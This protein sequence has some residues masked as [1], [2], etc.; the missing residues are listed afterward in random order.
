MYNKIRE[1]YHDFTPKFWV[2]IAAVFIDVI[3]STLV[4]P[5][6]ALYITKKF[7]VGM[8]QAGILLGL[9]S[10]FGLI[11]SMVGGALT[12]KFGRK[13]TTL[14]GDIF[15][16]SI[17]CL[18]WAVAQDFKTAHLVAEPLQLAV[19]LDLQLD[20][21]LQPH[22]QFG[23]LD[24][25]EQ[26]SVRAEVGVFVGALGVIDA[27]SVARPGFP[28]RIA[29]NP[30]YFQRLDAKLEVLGQAGD[31]DPLVAVRRAV[32]QHAQRVVGERGEFHGFG[33]GGRAGGRG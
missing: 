30:D 13:R 24:R 22:R 5:F 28:E 14:I 15:A 33:G 2:L 6:F 27:T 12:D 7:S 26:H 4:T 25:F 23:Q 21:A 29:I 20:H 3:G 9:F 18:I 1:T 10:I 11:G 8:T 16:W 31:R 32:H 19:V 17:P